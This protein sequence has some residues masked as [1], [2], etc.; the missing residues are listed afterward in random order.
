MKPTR[1]IKKK[2]GI[3]YWYEETPYYD[4]QKK[5]IRHK[6]KYLG[7]NIDGHPVR[8][9][10]ASDEIKVKT[11]NRLA[12]V[13]SSFDYGSI[14]TLQA[15]MEEL[16]LDSYLLDLL[17]PTEVAMVRALAFNRIIRP[18]AMKNV[19]SWYEGT[20]LVLESPQINLSSQRV[21]EFLGRLGESDIPDKFMARLLEGTGTK[22]TL[23][24][25][26][27]SLSSYSQLINLLEY[28]YNRDGESLPQINLSLILDKDKGIPVMYDIYPGSI[29]DVSTL[30]RTLQKIKAHGIYNYIAIM[31]RG[32]FSR[33]NLEE[34]VDSRLSFIMAA[35]LQLKDLKLLLNEAQEDIDNVKYLHKF[36]KDT[37][38]VKPI[39]YPV[40]PA[41]VKGYVYYDPKLEQFEKETLRSRLYDIR[42]DLIKIRLKKGS[43]AYSVF[44]EKAQGF[45]NFF[46][47]QLIDNRFEVAIK[48]N[49]VTQRMNKM[50]KYILFYSGDFDWMTCLAHYRERDEIEKSF[51]ALKNEIDILPLN[52]HG[53]KTTRGFIFVAFLSLIIRSRLMNRMREAGL[54]DKY[55]VELLLLQLDK[56]RKITL[57]DGHVIVTEM[58]KKQREILQAFNLC[59]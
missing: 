21:S 32:F 58:T 40:G 9:R 53:E 26:I 8:M 27:T 46:E 54:L 14:L 22:T 17:S 25:D 44:K 34:L 13:R 38:F 16:S 42:A 24:Y 15:I 31:D 11:K 41:I 45:V 5:Q 3:E 52:T 12:S 51:K 56:L 10:S 1:R 6:S 57:A 18:M 4:K 55:S 23:V 30:S 59:A 35:K 29:S 47:W 20:S 33:S 28:G 39:T 7:R 49:A 48:Q 19:D 37:I 36:G 43:E 50:G 2:N